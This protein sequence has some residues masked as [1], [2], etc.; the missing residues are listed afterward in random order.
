MLM[1]NV[2]KK[3][4]R[5]SSLLAPDLPS[6]KRQET[7][8]VVLNLFVLAALL[9]IHTLYSSVFGNPPL[10]LVIVLTTGFLANVIELIWVQGV[11]FL[12]PTV[13][14]GL[15]WATI[16]LNM[17]LAF[18][19][20]SLSYRQDMQ[21]FALFMGPI[22]QA[23]F[24]L[25]LSA[26]LS[27]VAA[28]TAL[29]FFWVW[30]YFHRHPPVQISEYLET[31]TISLIY[32]IAGILVWTLVHNLRNKEKDLRTSLIDLEQARERLVIEE[33]LAAV[34]RFSSAIAHEIRNPVAMISSALATAVG[35]QLDAVERKEMYDI[36][37][38]EASRLEK[39]T[40]DFL[41]YAR[42]RPPTMQ[43][44]EVAESVAYIADICRPRAAERAVEVQV[45]APDGLRANMDA[46][47]VQQALLNL[48][49]NAI[50]ASLSGGV[51][52]LRSKRDG[53][54]IRVE[55]ENSS[56]PIPP[57]AVDRV[58]EPFFTTKP[59]GTG[60]GLAIARNIA[61]G[62]GGELVLSRNQPGI[63]QFSLT[64]P[65]YTGESE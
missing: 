20:A 63:V 30:S 31:A 59:A 35:D 48:V 62:H 53:S 49:M 3:V 60:L 4:M 18:A 24:R 34:G 42:P 41:V 8:F 9:L 36:A 55:I 51:V 2:R 52:V 7:I 11:T 37:A 21:Y 40:T 57:E 27:V 56:G 23:A 6:F 38:K 10:L 44:C 22:L 1:A 5:E 12:S 50:E 65:A 33:K 32:A 17:T 61:R 14:V 64:L 16:S 25:S 15:T 39:L 13:I 28:S 47:Q 45:A 54:W 19:L 46:G 43:P 26:T 58:F 29:E